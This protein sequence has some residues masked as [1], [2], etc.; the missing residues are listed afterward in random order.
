M[1]TNLSGNLTYT[2]SPEYSPTTYIHSPLTFMGYV[3]KNGDVGIRNEIWIIPTVGCVNNVA[4][5]IA[6][7]ANMRLSGSVSEVMLDRLKLTAERIKE[8]LS[9]L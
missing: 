7:A 8:I 3:R 6:K 2:Y 1:K 9:K 4:T 5:A